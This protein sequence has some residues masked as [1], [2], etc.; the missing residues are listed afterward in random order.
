VESSARAIKR[1]HKESVNGQRTGEKERREK[2]TAE[3]PNGKKGGQA[4][5]EREPGR[6]K[7]S[8]ADDKETIMS[9]ILNP[10]A[11]S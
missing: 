9:T 6:H 11:A 8:D 4:G 7:H 3:D 5:Q 10:A 1:D 2:E